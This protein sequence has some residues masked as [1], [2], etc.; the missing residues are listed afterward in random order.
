MMSRGTVLQ[1]KTSAGEMKAN[2]SGPL[3]NANLVSEG[4]LETN[5]GAYRRNQRSK[6]LLRLEL[7]SDWRRALSEKL[8]EAVEALALERPPRLS[9]R[10]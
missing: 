6:I 8:R 10:G 1:R 2:Q 7:G 9:P 4:N 5:E 3:W